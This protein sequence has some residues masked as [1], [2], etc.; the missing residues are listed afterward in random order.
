[1]KRLIWLLLVL[2]L[3]SCAPAEIVTE[4]PSITENVIHTPSA[5]AT[6][7]MIFPTFTLQPA[8]LTIPT[9][10]I[11]GRITFVTHGI[12]DDGKIQSNIGVFDIDKQETKLLFNVPGGN[13]LQSPVWSPNGDQIAFIVS[14]VQTRI[15]SIY[16]ISLDG[17]EQKVI[18]V[19]SAITS[20]S[21]S[22]DGS[23]L[24]FAQ[25]AGEQKEIFLLDVISAQ[26]KPITSK[27]IVGS[28]PSWSPKG[29]QIAY[30]TFDM[31]SFGDGAH[32]YLINMADQS[33]TPLSNVMAGPNSKPA[34]SP[35]GTKLAFRS[36]DGCGDIYVLDLDTRQVKQ[37]TRTLGGEKDPSWSPD[38]SFLIFAAS[39]FVCDL[40]SGGE[41]LY[42]RW[43]P[44]LVKINESNPIP[45][46][47]SLDQ[48]DIYGFDWY[49][50]H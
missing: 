13:I 19:R 46:E 34:W 21:W 3:V 8:P 29:D 17:K 42:Q 9:K 47:L 44:F 38:G 25:D 10:P 36:K 15:E 26:I 12:G 5:T 48:Q 28:F 11:S 1:M 45:F 32:I 33:S 4:S 6:T 40:S 39:D 35:D 41:P 2:T 27:T 14:D 49:S 30:L 50:K 16:L 31:P 37:I 7:S 24:V 20:L 43:Q 22:P 18:E 23:T